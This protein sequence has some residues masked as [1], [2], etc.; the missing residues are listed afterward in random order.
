MA[1][2]QQKK[3]AA[4]TTGSAGSTGIPRAT[5]YG[6]YVISSVCRAF[7]SPSPREGS[8]RRL[9]PGVGGSGPHDFARPCRSPLALL[10]RHVHRILIPTFAAIGQTPL[11]ME[12][13]LA[14]TIIVFGKAEEK[15]LSMGT[16]SSQP[17]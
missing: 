1:R 14:H 5:V 10:R 11:Q 15:F 13:E 4:V 17:A 12:S 8:P 2:L 6:L 9:D 3:Q 7:E 16:G